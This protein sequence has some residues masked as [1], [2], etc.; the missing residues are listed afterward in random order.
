MGE[1]QEMSIK[2]Q[3][4]REDGQAVGKEAGEGVEKEAG[5]EGGIEAGQEVE[6]EAGQ[7]VEKKA[8]QEVEAGHAVEKTA[9][10]GVDK[11]AS[12]GVDKEAGQGVDIEAG[13]A[14]EKKAGQG[15]EKEA[16][17]GVDK[18]AGH[19]VEKGAGQEV[20]K[21]AGEENDH[22]NMHN[23]V[24]ALIDKMLDIAVHN[25]NNGDQCSPTAEAPSTPPLGLNS[26]QFL[27]NSNA[28][29]AAIQKEPDGSKHPNASTDQSE[30]SPSSNGLKESRFRL[31]TLEM[32]KPGEPIAGKDDQ[33][34][35]RR[36]GSMPLHTDEAAAAKKKADKRRL[37]IED[38]DDMLQHVG[39]WGR[40][41][42]LIFT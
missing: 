4:E 31:S 42:K 40:F 14:V 12:Q 3:Q 6:K 38:F 7:R 5:R 2:E 22:K 1:Q 10:Q 13:H 26:S 19:A 15:L 17:Q 34:G 20:D 9:G 35:T 23:N 8:G 39:S 33:E 11:E 30:H 24:T 16:G 36:N 27:Q 21:E 37:P 41:V 18:E 29:M 25:G 28:K 32:S